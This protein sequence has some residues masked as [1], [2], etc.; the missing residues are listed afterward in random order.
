MKET[1]GD[2]TRTHGLSKT[3][4]YWVWS[5]IIDR[6]ENPK[7]RRY[8]SYGAKG[9]YLCTEWRT[10]FKKF[11]DWAMEKGWKRG[12]HVD[13][14]IIPRKLGIEAKVYSPEMC[15]IVT[16]TD[17]INCT[18]SNKY[19]IYNGQEKT[20]AQWAKIKNINPFII[21]KRLR[22]GWSVKDAIETPNIS[23]RKLEYLKRNEK[24]LISHSF[25]FINA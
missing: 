1:I 16:R 24:K 8:K 7:N 18:S 3:P 23:G 20:V 12:M 25:G 13:K 14:D 11:Y 2:R 9:I 17:N 5:T 4:L 22:R 21:Y 6:C 15:S 19:I 10:D